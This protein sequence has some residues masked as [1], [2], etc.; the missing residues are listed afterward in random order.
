MAQAHFVWIFV[1]KRKIC[2]RMNKCGLAI[3]IEV[4]YAMCAF[5]QKKIIYFGFF[6]IHTHIHHKN[7]SAILISVAQSLFV[8]RFYKWRP[9]RVITTLMYPF[10]R[11]G[12]K[13]HLFIMC[14]NFR[15]RVCTILDTGIIFS[16]VKSSLA[17][18]AA[19]AFLFEI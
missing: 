9:Q 12:K 8:I 11:D 19:D 16:F 6:R 10:L 2:K 7:L 18:T 14:S 17:S 3:C 13:F 1:Q 5:W 15:H 4:L